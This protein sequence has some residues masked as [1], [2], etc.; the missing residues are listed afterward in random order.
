MKQKDERVKL[1][2]EVLTGIEVLNESLGL[3]KGV[4]LWSYRRNCLFS[5]VE[6]VCEGAVVPRANHGHTKEGDA[7][8]LKTSLSPCYRS[9][10]LKLH[11]I[12]D[13]YLLY[14][15]YGLFSFPFKNTL[16]GMLGISCY[17]RP[18]RLE[19]RSWCI[20]GIPVSEPFSNRVDLSRSCL[21]IRTH[22]GN[23]MA[24]IGTGAWHNFRSISFQ[25][26]VSVKRI[27]N[28]INA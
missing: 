21:N 7:S 24:L 1:M 17:L 10:S 12:F 27:N 13:I 16:A 4:T 20:Q 5:G 25:T 15:V 18:D 14:D 26:Q 22:S 23:W 11:S 2:N 9:S 6:V 3:Y 28:F 8:S 19:S